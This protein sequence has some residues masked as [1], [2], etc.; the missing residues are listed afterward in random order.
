MESEFLSQLDKHKYVHY[1]N[2][3]ITNILA[4]H[5]CSVQMVRVPVVIQ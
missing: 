1:T 2:H 3:V 5:T 4:F